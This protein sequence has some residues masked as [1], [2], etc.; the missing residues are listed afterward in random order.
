[1]VPSEDDLVVE[2]QRA[3]QRD[4]L[5]GPPRRSRRQKLVLAGVVLLVVGA[6]AGVTAWIRQPDP[7]TTYTLAAWHH[8][9]VSKDGRF[10]EVSYTGGDCGTESVRTVVRE[11]A[12][13][14][15]LTVV[16]VEQGVD[17]GS[18]CLMMGVPARAVARLTRPLG[19][20][21]LVDGRC[22][23]PK[24]LGARSGCSVHGFNPRAWPPH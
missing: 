24:S 9:V 21:T 11:T 2:L 23:E 15:A 10:V 4:S 8:P 18:V 16:V 14:V 6:L 13:R 5:T 22:Q 17:D 3:G 1:M 20:R 12:Q 7:Y 19:S